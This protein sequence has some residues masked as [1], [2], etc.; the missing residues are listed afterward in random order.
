[1]PI[2]FYSPHHAYGCF[3]NFSPHGV[4]LKGKWWPTS[5]H[6]FQAQKFAGTPHEEEIR[7]AKTPKQAATMGRDRGRPLRKDWEHVKDS[8]MRDAVREKFRTHKDIRDIL[9]GTGDEPIIENAPNDYYWGCG[10][11][12]SGQNRLGE[13]LMQVRAELRA[14]SSPDVIQEHPEMP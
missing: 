12:G 1:M 4:H 10:A 7:H 6:Y 8:I 2:T 5:E 3:S 14:E 13:I 11:N 9:L